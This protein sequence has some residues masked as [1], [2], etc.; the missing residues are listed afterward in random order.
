MAK[1]Y[2]AQ[3]TGAELVRDAQFMNWNGR[4]DGEQIQAVRYMMRRFGGVPAD[5]DMTPVELMR[6]TQDV[7]FPSFV[8]NMRAGRV[9]TRYATYFARSAS[10]RSDRRLTSDELLDGLDVMEDAATEAVTA[11]TTG[12]PVPAFQTAPTPQAQIDASILHLRSRQ[13]ATDASIRIMGE[14]FAQVNGKLRDMGAQIATALKAR[15][16]VV[17]LV[18]DGKTRNFDAS[19]QHK[20][21]PELLAAVGN[22]MNVMLVGPAGC[23]K[24]HMAAEVAR[25]LSLNFDF[26]GAVANEFKLSGFRNA[27]GVY[28]GTGYRK[29]YE[30]GGLFLC[31]E[32]DASS[33]NALLYMNSGLA[34]SIQDFPDTAVTRHKD[35]RFIASANTY[36]HGADRQYVGRNQLDAATLDRYYVLPIDYDEGLEFKL[37]GDGEWVRYVHKVRKA[38]RELQLRHVVSMRAID[39]GCTML[40]AGVDRTAVERAVLWR[41][42]PQADIDRIRRGLQ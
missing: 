7:D 15:P 14:K 38:V 36:G 39:M 11:P 24:T 42:L 27:E 30:H 12:Q 9:D 3:T 18:Q 13:D 16:V 22:G 33:A 31:D 40:A 8:A 25:T 32:I 1:R 35:F 4:P 26:T 20:M 23:G 19:M 37:Y 17:Q 41:N 28:I 34:N 5:R 29:M 6:M 2:N 10:T 21:F